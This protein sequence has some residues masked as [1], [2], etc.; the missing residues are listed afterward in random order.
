MEALRAGRRFERILVSSESLLN[1]SLRQAISRARTAGMV[2]EV[3]ERRELERHATTK[4]SQG[5]VAFSDDARYATLEAVVEAAGKAPLLACVLD[6]IQ[7]PHNLGAI[8]RTLEVAGGHGLLLKRDKSVGITPGALRAAAGALEH[9]PVALVKS[10][11]ETLAEL[12][13]RGVHT[14]GLSEHATERTIY[15]VKCARPL[16][17][18]VGNEHRGLSERTREAC[19]ELAS[20]PIYGRI[21][22]LNASVA[23]ALM[24]Y[25]AARQRATA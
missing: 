12:K 4:K 22:S 21:G 1:P 7:D 9:L 16:A 10:V 13:Q 20:I 19:D 14:V 25:E 17:I 6:G 15:E 5:I 8:A 18:V 2:V 23:A 24:C 11:P 3:V